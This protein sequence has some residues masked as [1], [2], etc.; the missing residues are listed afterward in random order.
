MSQDNRTFRL[1]YNGTRF[2]GARLP[3]D[4]LS[5]MSAFRDLLLAYARDNWRARNA[6]RKRLPKGF[7]GSISLDLVTIED[8]SA[9]PNL[10]W[11]R[12]RSQMMLPDFTDEIREAV[13]AA[14]D[15]MIHLFIEAGEGRYPKTLPSQ[16]IRA[17]NKFGAN[18]KSD[19]RIVFIDAGSN[20]NVVYLDPIRRKALITHVKET[21]Q[22]ELEG[23]GELVMNHVDGKITIRTDQFGELQ[24]PVPP[25]RIKLDFDGNI[26]ATLQFSLKVELDHSDAIKWVTEVLSIELVDTEMA[27]GLSRRKRRLE[28]LKALVAG[29][30]DGEGVPIS[31]QAIDSCRSFLARRASFAKDYRIYPTLQGG[32]LVEFIAGAWD[33]SVEFDPAGGVEFLGVEVEGDREFGPESFSGVDDAF[34][35]LFDTKTRAD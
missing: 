29:W 11:S 18:L 28:E 32:I 8:G 16:Q 12:D 6:D 7:D 35:K 17:L 21:Y 15:N 10:E 2:N 34:L 31:R 19:E 4:V 27:D 14:Y 20:D 30:H 33:L 22:T 13:D 23:T 24:L 3:V 25:E 26:G 1:K 9:I 5:D